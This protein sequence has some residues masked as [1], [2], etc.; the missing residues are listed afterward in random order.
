[1]QFNLKQ[2]L[3]LTWPNLHH[4]SCDC[5]TETDAGLCPLVLH[6]HLPNSHMVLCNTWKALYNYWNSPQTQV[7]IN[8]WG[9]RRTNER[10]NIFLSQLLFIFFH[11]LSQWL[12]S[13]TVIPP[14]SNFKA[15]SLHLEKLK[16]M[17][18]MQTNKSKQIKGVIVQSQFPPE[19]FWFRFLTFISPQPVQEVEKISKPGDWSNQK[20]SLQESF[21]KT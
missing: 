19:L 14:V 8:L 11:T 13:L 7:A 10:E 9:R 1:M 21:R 18:D 16:F 6:L 2:D 15:R 3:L 4:W 12:I 17:R 5:K 20:M